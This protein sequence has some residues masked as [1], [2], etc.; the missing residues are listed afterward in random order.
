MRHKAQRDRNFQDWA[1]F[2]DAVDAPENGLAGAFT[3]WAW[4]ADQIAGARSFEEVRNLARFGWADGAQ[5]IKSIALPIVE[6][7]VT[8]RATGTSWEWDVTGAAYDVG[9]YLSGVPECWLTATPEETKPVVTIQVDL[10]LRASIPGRIV[11][12]RGAG[13]VALTLALQAAGYVVDI[14]AICGSGISANGDRPYW[15]RVPLVDANGGPL[16]TDR[17]LFA[18]AHPANVRVCLF[19]LGAAL[20]GHPGSGATHQGGENP[21]K[22]NLML[23][24]I[25]TSDADWQSPAAVSAWVK[26]TFEQLTQTKGDN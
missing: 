18:L 23:P 4:D 25:E 17:L 10:G 9:E 11:T 6:S 2:L 13:L 21:W 16:D 19:G 5:H 24:R 15:L 7:V 26:R 8:R 1:E 20:H 14:A 12:L 3:A 22:A